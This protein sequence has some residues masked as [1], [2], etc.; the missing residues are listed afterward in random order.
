MKIEQELVEPTSGQKVAGV[1]CAVFGVP[2]RFLGLLA[3]FFG[4]RIGL[5]AFEAP[6]G[7]LAWT[8]LIYVGGGMVALVVGQV[9]YF[10]RLLLG[11]KVKG[12][13]F[14]SLEKWG[15]GYVVRGVSVA[16]GVAGGLA[17]VMHLFSEET[18]VAPSSLVFGLVVVSFAVARAGKKMMVQSRRGNIERN[19]KNGKF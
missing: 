12:E 7:M 17:L 4:V 5:T 14:V 15:F 19:L 11:G 9:L 8:F 10:Y 2:I 6:V 1:V 18:N 3:L 16:A 13:N